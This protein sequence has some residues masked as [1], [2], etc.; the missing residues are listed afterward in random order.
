MPENEE[1]KRG[2]HNNIRRTL[3]YS[4]F[5]NIKYIEFKHLASQEDFFELKTPIEECEEGYFDRFMERYV[6]KEKIN[7]RLLAVQKWTV[8]RNDKGDGLYRVKIY[9]MNDDEFREKVYPLSYLDY[10]RLLWFNR[11]RFRVL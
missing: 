11:K 4:I 6:S 3:F 10:A 9:H 7:G 8:N 5:R 1:L 2:T